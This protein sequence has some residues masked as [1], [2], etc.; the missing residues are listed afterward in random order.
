M[1]HLL[2]DADG[3]ELADGGALLARLQRER[4][5]GQPELHRAV[6]VLPADRRVLTQLTARER[7]SPISKKLM[8][9]GRNWKGRAEVFGHIRW[10]P[11]R[12]LH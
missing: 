1:V 7:S 4:R 6:L 10:T 12:K 5:P 3:E 2:E 9:C 11:M 8:E